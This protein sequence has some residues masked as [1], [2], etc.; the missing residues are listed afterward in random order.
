MVQWTGWFGVAMDWVVWGVSV[1]W[2]VLGSN[3]LGCLGCFSGMGS[4]G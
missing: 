1:A 3:G 2:E 4:F